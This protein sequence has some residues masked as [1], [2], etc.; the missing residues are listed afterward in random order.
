[1]ADAFT[2]VVQMAQTLEYILAQRYYATGRGLHE[3]LTSVEDE[4]PE[5]ARKQIRFVATL[6]N[7]AAHEDVA[8]AEQNLAAITR[9]YNSA[10]AALDGTT[11]LGSDLSSG[12]RAYG[13]RYG[14]PVK[15]PAG[16]NRRAQAYPSSDT[17]SYARP[18]PAAGP[19]SR[20]RRPDGKS[21]PKPNP[22]LN[23]PRPVARPSLQGRDHAR[24]NLFIGIVV[25]LV[26]LLIVLCILLATVVLKGSA[27]QDKQTGAAAVRADGQTLV[28]SFQ[29][30]N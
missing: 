18:K 26:A 17:R 28:S 25:G 6:R 9:A 30:E 7:K 12:S 24:A 13:D 11:L 2:Q 16:P 27:N 3:K 20:E 29:A 15:L 14:R 1:M 4:V 10:L 21:K 5:S 8:L 19:K 22:A 23:R